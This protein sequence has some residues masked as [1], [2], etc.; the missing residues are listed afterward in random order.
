[1]D[2]KCLTQLSFFG[3]ML[4]GCNM[5]SDSC[6]SSDT[7][8]LIYK[9][10]TEQAV[11]SITQKRDDHYDGALIFGATKIRASLAQI[12]IVLENI[13]I[14]KQDPESN[15][16]ICTGQ[17][18]VTVP[19]PMLADVDLA[20]GVQHQINIA[21][22]ARQLHIENSRNA[23]TQVVE[24]SVK[25]TADDKEASIAFKSTAWVNLL[26]EITT[27]VL[28]KPTLDFQEIGNVQRDGQPIQEIEQVKPETKTIS[29]NQEKEELDKLNKEFFKAKPI[30]KTLPKEQ[31]SQ[32]NTPQPLSP[33]STIKPTS[34]GFDCNKA[35]KPT[36]I[37]IC[38]ESGLAVLDVENMTLY[39]NAKIID[40]VITKEIWMESI[41]SKYACGT[42]VDCIAKAYKKS[43]KRYQCVATKNKAC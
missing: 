33:E 40:P 14:V 19:P 36:D 2:I 11:N 26:D 30:E 12:H 9:H 23:F 16:S 38:A 41:K 10:L 7:Q 3:L 27:A 1:M 32:P 42:D 24:Y 39:K 31:A 35:K 8:Q 28:L 37:T 15:I 25:S 21:Q 13:K 17:L 43:I 5:S 34:P 18:K 22:Y 6:S 29:A 4:S 20:R